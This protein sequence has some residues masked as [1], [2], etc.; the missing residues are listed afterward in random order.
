MLLELLPDTLV[1][2][3]DG[4]FPPE[5]PPPTF[6]LELDLVIVFRFII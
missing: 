2:I 6:P 4:L 3:I 5:I 1:P